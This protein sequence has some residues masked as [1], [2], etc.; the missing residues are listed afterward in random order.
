M[1][2]ALGS[3]YDA[4]HGMCNA[5]LLPYVM[6]YNLPAVEFKYARVARAMG[7]EETDD[8]QAAVK[9][10]EYIKKLS[11]EVGLPGIRSLKINKNDFVRLAK[12]SVK[13]GSNA[14]NPREIT[15]ADYV[16]LFEKAY[17]GCD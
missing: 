7:I 15:E 10:I 14:S 11:I 16:M 6:E 13:N 8:H 17:H 4:P 5:I 9:G 3:M 12:M 2:E 1:A